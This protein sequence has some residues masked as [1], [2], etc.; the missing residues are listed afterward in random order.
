MEATRLFSED[1]GRKQGSNLCRA[2]RLTFS[3]RVQSA[4]VPGLERGEGDPV[5][6]I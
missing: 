2:T 5:L 3:V 6:T 4:V 1:S